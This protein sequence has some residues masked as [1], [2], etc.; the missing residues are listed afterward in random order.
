MLDK[1][2]IEWSDVDRTEALESAIQ[3]SAEK[4]LGRA[5]NATNLIV[6]LKIVNPQKSAGVKSQ[7]VSL[8][9]RLPNHRDVRSEKEGDDLYH[10]ILEA[11]KALLTQLQSQKPR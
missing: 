1:L 5:P 8:E 2:Q 9:L 11:E 10:S 7:K 3:S 6:G 4:I